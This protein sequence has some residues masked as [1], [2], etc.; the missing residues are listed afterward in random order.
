M[1]RALLS[2]IVCVTALVAPPLGRVGTANGQAGSN[3]PVSNDS[4]RALLVRYCVGCH[5][6]KLKTAGLTLDTLSL[7]AVG[8]DAATWEKVVRKLRAGLMPP[9]GSPRPDKASYDGLASWLE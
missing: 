1:S 9:A 5:N 6:Q 2:M 7:A 8:E 3:A 4:Q